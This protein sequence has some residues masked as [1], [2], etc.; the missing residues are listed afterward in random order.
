MCLNI[1][2]CTKTRKRN[3]IQKNSSVQCKAMQRE[4]KEKNWKKNILLE[5]GRVVVAFP[6]RETKKEEKKNK[7]IIQKKMPGKVSNTSLACFFSTL[8]L[9]VFPLFSA[10]NFRKSL[11]IF[12]FL[13]GV[14]ERVYRPENKK[15]KQEFVLWKKSHKKRQQIR[16]DRNDGISFFSCHSLFKF[17]VKKFKCLRLQRLRHP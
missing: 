7:K 6:E 3:H 12:F 8:F 2:H 15:K 5:C 17:S 14:N 1:K 13:H 11:V 4:K 16:S 9:C 10:K